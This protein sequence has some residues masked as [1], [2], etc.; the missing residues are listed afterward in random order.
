MCII[1]PIKQECELIVITFIELAGLLCLK[2]S[3]LQTYGLILSV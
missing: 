3:V 1:V 2:T